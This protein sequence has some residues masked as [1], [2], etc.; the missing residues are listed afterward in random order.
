[1]ME[2]GKHDHRLD[3]LFAAYREACSPPEAGADFM[4]RLWERIESR[5]RW[6]DPMW[7]WA[8]GL[9]AVAAF[10]SLFFVLL[11]V[12]PAK[13]SLTATRSY[14]EMLAE[15]HETEEMEIQL[16]SWSPGARPGADGAGR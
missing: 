3:E 1:M 11:Q 16:A 9:A 12:L 2:P 13:S 14:V 4:P 8:N 5:K 15:E 10:A 7:R 6:I